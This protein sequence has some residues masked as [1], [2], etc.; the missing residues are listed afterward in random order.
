MA[1]CV[2]TIACSPGEI[3]TEIDDDNFKKLEVIFN[4]TGRGRRPSFP[5]LVVN[6]RL[7]LQLHCLKGQK[8]WSEIVD[9]A[10]N[11]ISLGKSRLRPLIE[12]TY[13]DALNM[14][15]D[16]LKEFCD[17]E[18]TFVGLSLA[19]QHVTREELLGQIST[20]R[21]ELLTITNAIALDLI[22]FQKKEGLSSTW[23]G[24]AVYYLSGIPLPDAVLNKSMKA[25]QL[26]ARKKS[27]KRG[28]NPEEYNDFMDMTLFK[29]NCDCEVKSSPPTPE[30]PAA[31][32]KIK[33]D[34]IHDP[35]QNQSIELLASP[36]QSAN[37]AIQIKKL[38]G[39]IGAVMNELQ[40][41]KLQ[42]E[43]LRETF[44]EREKEYKSEIVQKT[45]QLELKEKELSKYRKQAEKD[46][47]LINEKTKLISTIRQAPFYKRLKRQ[48]RR[49]KSK[50]IRMQEDLKSESSLL[51]MSV[52]EK[53]RK[54]QTL[55]SNSR[56]ICDSKS[57]ELRGKHQDLQKSVLQKR[58]EFLVSKVPLIQPTKQPNQ[59]YR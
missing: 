56:Q 1:D 34:N 54:T 39:R 57:S 3:H 46:T 55:L 25:L 8:T 17:I 53:L 13:K 32:K 16:E 18:Q 23:I 37:R 6:N 27:Q 5:K 58:R 31:V 50:E 15:T 45:A 44:C 10:S 51:L 59:E 30:T 38:E 48:E 33:L 22:S 9:F 21:N 11:I 35:D 42:N 20:T 4:F 47:I 14:R 28:R 49:L 26:S 12:K 36:L 52:K 29:I 24:E 2:D 43:I 19:K 40:N 41:E 7:L